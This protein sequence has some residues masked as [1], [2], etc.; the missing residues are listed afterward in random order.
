MKKLNKNA[1]ESHYAGRK[2]GCETELATN[3]KPSRYG[4]GRRRAW[5]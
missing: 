4:D 3:T 2:E 5:S 1:H